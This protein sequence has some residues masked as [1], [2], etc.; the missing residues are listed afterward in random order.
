MPDYDWLGYGLLLKFSNGTVFIQGDEASV[1]YDQL[2]A[3]ATS[4]EI[5]LLLSDYA[6]MA[7]EES[8]E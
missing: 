7:E 3:C 6:A 4:E 2:E 8:D 1:L 5:D